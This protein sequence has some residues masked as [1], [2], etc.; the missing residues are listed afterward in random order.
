MYR[1][2]CLFIGSLFVTVSAFAVCPLCS[3]AVG[4]GIGLTQYLGID[5]TITGFWIGGLIVSMISWSN[6]WIKGKNLNF[7]GYK[8][9]ITAVYYA[10]FIIPL[11]SSNIVGHELNKLY[12]VDKVLL[13]VIMGS[14][15]FFLGSMA[16]EMLKKMNGG[17]AQFPFQKIVMP[18]LPLA[19]LSWVFYY[20]TK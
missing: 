2:I 9:L 5:D 16:Y 17:R 15:V 7:R 13:G 1:Y 14:V 4:A 12:G 3:F 18:I 11:Y 6:S 10:A 8:I 20:L 19:C